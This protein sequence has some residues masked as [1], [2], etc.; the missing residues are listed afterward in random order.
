MGKDFCPNFLQ[1]FLENVDRRSC[2]YGSRGLIPVFYNP[3][4]ADLF[5]RRWLATA[6]TMK[7]CPPRPR[8]AGGRKNK[9]REHLQGGN[10][11]SPKFSL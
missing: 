11:V 2:N 3:Q 10:Q 5:L 9:V 4:N 1:P 8:W 6:S 7:R